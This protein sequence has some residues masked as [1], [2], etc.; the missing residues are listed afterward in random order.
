MSL[1][2]GEHLPGNLHDP[3]NFQFGRFSSLVIVL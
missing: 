1:P 2:F 3:E